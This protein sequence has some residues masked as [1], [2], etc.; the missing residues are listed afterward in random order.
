MWINYNDPAYEKDEYIMVKDGVYFNSVTTV[1]DKTVYAI[2]R[3]I[4]GIMTF[5]Q[6]EDLPMSDPLSLTAQIGKARDA[7]SREA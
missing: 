4:G 7:F 3:G 6:D 1:R 2:L 5:S